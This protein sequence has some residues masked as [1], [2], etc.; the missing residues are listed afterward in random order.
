MQKIKHYK[1]DSIF[2]KVLW[3][4]IIDMER[5]EFKQGTL[6][7][8]RFRVEKVVSGGSF[9]DDMMTMSMSGMLGRSSLFLVMC[10][11]C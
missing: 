6:S 1:L 7:E 5:F 11:F 10:V 8:S 3:E 9:N 4:S 2:S